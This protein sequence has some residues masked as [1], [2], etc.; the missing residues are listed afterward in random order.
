MLAFIG[1]SEVDG[2]NISAISRN[3]AITKYKAEIF[4]KLL[5]KAFILN[6]IYPAG[7][8]VLKE[9]KVLM[10]LPYRLLYKDWDQCIGA[11]REDFFAEM[12]AM[13]GYEFQYLKTK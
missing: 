5:A 6:P 12:L 3:L 2:I 9:P 7:T 4:V 11:I 10:F 8:N 13:K 1:K